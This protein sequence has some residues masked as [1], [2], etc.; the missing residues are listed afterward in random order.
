M[1]CSTSWA[2]ATP[3][4]HL[5]QLVQLGPVVIERAIVAQTAET[6]H[7]GSDTC[8]AHPLLK[9]P[10]ACEHQ[11]RTTVLLHHVAG[12]DSLH[13]FPGNTWHQ[14]T[15][16]EKG[17]LAEAVWRFG[18]TLGPTLYSTFST[19]NYSNQL[20]MACHDSDQ[21]VFHYNQLPPNVHGRCHSNAC[22]VI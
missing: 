10:W 18:R 22:P 6:V 9:V 8:W 5:S 3:F 19:T 11:N 12:W 4:I 2:P 20:T 13:G 14:H 7:A 15:L 17:K 1:T 21:R 16:R